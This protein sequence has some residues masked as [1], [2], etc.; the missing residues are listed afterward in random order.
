VKIYTAHQIR[1]W[2]NY[3][4][5]NEPISSFH[6][7]ERAAQ[8]CTD[9]II[10]N[11]LDHKPIKIFCGKG[12]NGGDGLAIARQLAEQ[13]ISSRVYI[14]E[15]GHLGSDDFQANLHLLHQY[16]ADIS[17]IQQETSFPVIKKEDIVID[18]L[19]G[20]GLNRRLEGLSAALVQHINSAAA[21][22]IAIDLPSGM[23]ADQ[24]SLE[25]TVVKASF[26]LTF[27][28]YKLCFLLPENEHLTGKVEV[29]DIGLHPQ[30]TSEV[31]P[32]YELIDSQFIK[33]IYKP[34][35]NFSHKGTYGH[36]LIV[37]G[38][39]GKMGAAYLASKACLRSGCGLLTCLIPDIG[40][41]VLQT[42]LP[43]AM[44]ITTENTKAVDYNAYASIAMGPGLGSD[45]E[46]LLK[47]VL[48]SYSK[49]IVIDAEGL[50]ILSRNKELLV[51]L[52]KGS[53]L[54]PH[55]KEYERL[56]G[57]TKN[58]FDRLENA[59]M[60]AKRLQAYILIKGH[61]SFIACPEGCGFFNSTGNAGMATA[62]SGDVLTGIITG[63]LAQSY[64][65][66]EAIVLGVYL[67]GL[68]GDIA[69]NVTSQEAMIAGDIIENLGTAFHQ[70]R[71]A[72]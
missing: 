13:G 17:F 60:N 62:G 32:K 44:C 15:F 48:N 24:S 55:P 31:L 54:T 68:A 29:F 40:L 14:L 36:A 49:S 11:E 9:W 46:D 65:S 4:I 37:A 2:D 61:H 58:N 1:E 39:K 26:T 51:H 63:L 67:H 3:T 18:A 50:N 16:T 70:I 7:M 71:G 25:S 59:M 56:F 10:K 69:A 53:I 35:N 41:D 47:G 33:H 20:S 52:P 45:K 19:Y 64:S 57:A 12:N 23:F 5:K 43:E 30:Y 28:T 66:L 22:V 34:R 6:L 8:T 42:S 27:Q 72:G 38:S 21:L